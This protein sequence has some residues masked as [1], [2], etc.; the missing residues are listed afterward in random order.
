[1][2]FPT[3]VAM[4]TDQSRICRL[5]KNEYCTPVPILTEIVEDIVE[6]SDPS[7]SSGR[8][9]PHLCEAKSAVRSVCNIFR[10]TFRTMQ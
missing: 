3:V 8:S 7:N 9:V 5:Q 6:V 2:N 10:F 1:M 4:L